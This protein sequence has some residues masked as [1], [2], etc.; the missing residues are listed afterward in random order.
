MNLKNVHV[1]ILV[2]LGCLVGVVSC[3][4]LHSNIRQPAS[5][6]EEASLELPTTYEPQP[7]A[8]VEAVESA[9]VVVGSETPSES[10]VV[11]K[12]EVTNPEVDSKNDMVGPGTLKPTVYYFVIIDEDKNTCPS[13]SKQTLHGAGGKSLLSVCPK[14]AQACGLQGSCGVIQKGVTHTFNIIGRFEGQ[15]R[16]FEI[17]EDGCRFGYGVRSSCL[18]PFYTLAADLEIY[19]PG[20][21]IFVP[22][23]VGLQLPDGSKHNGYFV[24]RDKGRGVKGLGR[25]DF[26]SGFYS[27][28]DPKNPFKK[29]GLGDIKTNIPYFRVGGETAKKVLLNRAFP[30]LPPSLSS[31]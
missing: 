19:K 8:E 4:K 30:Q 22:A 7:F 3:G 20:E 13:E 23:V 9:E 31:K 27:W 21:V 11:P 2:L 24:I 28:Y 29:L 26:F 18:D 5:S 14:T 16:Y 10:E 17:E 1:Q 12:P 6:L 25:F 15:D